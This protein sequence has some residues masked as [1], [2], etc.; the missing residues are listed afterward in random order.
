MLVQSSLMAVWGPLR[1][2]QS[3]CNRWLVS[4]SSY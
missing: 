3:F 1:A 4:A 2:F